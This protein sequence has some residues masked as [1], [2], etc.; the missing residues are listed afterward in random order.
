MRQTKLDVWRRL[1]VGFTTV[2]LALAGPAV[3]LATPAAAQ[4]DRL[5]RHELNAL[6][7]EMVSA[8]LP[9][10]VG[11]ARRGSDTWRGASGLAVIDPQR[12]MRPTDRW[13]V[14]SLTKT[15][16][17][18]VVLQLAGEGR[19]GLDDSVER[20]LP[21]LVPNGGNITLRELLNHSSGLF[22]Y[23][24][25][26]RILA[27]YLAGDFGFVWTPLQLVGVAMSHP[28]LFPPGDHHSYSNTGYILLGLVVE[29]VTGTSLG[30]QLRRR[31]FDPLDLQGTSFPTTQQRV[32]GS[33]AHGYYIG[34]GP[35]GGLL[36][37]TEVSPSWAW[38]AGAM[39]S[40]SD[41][42]A[43]FLRAL[44]RG[45]LLPPNL[46]N[47][48][49]T[50]IPGGSPG[51]RYGLGIAALDTPCGT[52]WGHDGG[53]QYQTWAL[54]SRDADRQVVMMVNANDGASVPLLVLDQVARAHCLLAET[55]AL[56]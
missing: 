50:T 31:I 52:L 11:L 14:G 20:W 21:G 40:T 56:R 27:P 42:L 7:D 39:V 33:L 49:L 2:T 16:V 47:Q 44:L 15:A 8:G 28:P 45:R 25:D 4:D 1:A 13:G 43:R 22:N 35:N 51:L 9:G 53:E 10:A 24:D 54:N 48:M 19:L 29:K 6:L 26:P 3:G 12:E 36:D 41:D 18:T 30:T 5:P 32:T 34:V 38:A 17:A 55:P 46:L 23:T 37:A